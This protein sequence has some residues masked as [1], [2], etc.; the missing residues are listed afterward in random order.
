MFMVMTIIAIKTVPNNNVIN[1]HNTKN[2]NSI[3]IL[4]ITFMQGI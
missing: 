4:V 2:D 3:I 1:N